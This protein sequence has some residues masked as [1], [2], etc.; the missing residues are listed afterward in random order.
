MTAEEKIQRGYMVNTRWTGDAGLY[1]VSYVQRGL[2]QPR[3]SGKAKNV[4]E[5]V[6]TVKVLEESVTWDKPPADPEMAVED[7]AVDALRRARIVGRWITL[8]TGLIR[9]VEEWAK[10]LGWSAKRIEK[11]MEDSEV[12]K[13]LAPALLLQEE[14]TKVLLEPITRRAPGT[15]GVVDLY[16]MPGYDDIASLY[17][18]KNRWNLHY[19]SGEQKAVANIREAEAKPLTKASFNRVLEEMKANAQ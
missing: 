18:H 3:M 10:N 8:L 15:E 12:G 5:H 11:P 9:S 14:T 19:A 13:Y 1:R 7:F 4:S 17:Y 6:A 16:L 2:R